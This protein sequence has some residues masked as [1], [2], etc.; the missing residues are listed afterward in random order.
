MEKKK[1]DKVLN[2]FGCDEVLSL[3][4]EVAKAGKTYS[5]KTRKAGAVAYDVTNCYRAVYRA[6]KGGLVSVQTTLMVAD[7]PVPTG[8]QIGFLLDGGRANIESVSRGQ[9][10]TQR[11]EKTSEKEGRGEDLK[12]LHNLASLTRLE[13]LRT[14]NIVTVSAS[15]DDIIGLYYVKS[16]VE[17]NPMSVL[18]MQRMIQMA[19]GKVLPIYMY[20]MKSGA[21]SRKFTQMSEIDAFFYYCKDDARVLESEKVVYEDANGNTHSFNIFGDQPIDELFR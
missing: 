2:I 18:M 10:P 3:P 17:I 20:D 15:F 16:G 9:L 11:K 7:Y 13:S 12:T 4:I 21:L 6:R 19:T 5:D 8:S 1:K 14:Q